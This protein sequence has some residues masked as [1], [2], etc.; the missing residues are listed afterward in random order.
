VRLPGFPVSFKLWGP[1]K[2]RPEVAWLEGVGGTS[3][4]GLGKDVAGKSQRMLA[5]EQRGLRSVIATAATMQCGR[6][7]SLTVWRQHSESHSSGQQWRIVCM[8]Y[9][10]QGLRGQ[11]ALTR[12]H[13]RAAATPAAATP[14]ATPATTRRASR[15]WISVF[16]VWCVFV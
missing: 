13:A 10:V 14:L 1:R 11:R 16:L 7:G 6:C 8:R 4:G 3:K 5:A 12:C 9:R 15:C 2:A